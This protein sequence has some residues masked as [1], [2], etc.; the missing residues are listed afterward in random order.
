[1]T[2]NRCHV[3]FALVGITSA[4]SGTAAHGQN[5][6]GRWRVEYHTSALAVEEVKELGKSPGNGADL[7]VAVKLRNVSGRSITGI[8]ISGASP[9]TIAYAPAKTEGL[10]PDATCT[11]HVAIY[12]RSDEDRVIRVVAVLFTDRIPDDGDSAAIAHMRCERSGMLFGYARCSAILSQLD[13]SRLDD[14][15]IQTG[16][17]ELNSMPGRDVSSAPEFSEL[18]SRLQVDRRISGAGPDAIHS[19]VMGV[20]GARG[21]CRT[22]IEE[23][24]R[25]TTCSVPPAEQNRVGCLQGLKRDYQT[26]ISTFRALADR[27][28]EVER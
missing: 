14:A 4:G 21:L 7:G 24:K 10:N 13:P 16:I 1:M 19:I 5:G 6:T 11:M 2:G 12:P 9:E 28:L 18:K 22:V 23:M 15:S 3:L 8:A 20:E 25:P 26:R 17:Q 27:D